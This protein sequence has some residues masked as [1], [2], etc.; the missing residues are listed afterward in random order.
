MAPRNIISG[1]RATGIWP[2]DPSKVQDGPDA[3]IEDGVP[4]AL[5]PTPQKAVS[6]TKDSALTTPQKSQDVLKAQEKAREHLSPTNRT[7]RV[8]F[9]K[10]GRSLDRKNPY[11]ASFVTPH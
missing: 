11:A 3:V 2:Y 8:L 10:V 5:P 6:N 7:V 1:F 9:N 4:P